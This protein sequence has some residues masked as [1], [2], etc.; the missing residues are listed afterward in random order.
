MRDKGLKPATVENVHTV[1][2][3][4]LTMA[5]RDCLIRNNPADSVMME[6]KKE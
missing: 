3:P 5:V 4:T 2:H 1:V 6:I